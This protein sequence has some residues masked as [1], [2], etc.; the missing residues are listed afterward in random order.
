MRTWLALLIP[1]SHTGAG[2]LHLLGEVLSDFGPKVETSPRSPASMVSAI[3]LSGRVQMESER[4][5]CA[6]NDLLRNGGC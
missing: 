4:D 3:D 6:A 1:W 2:T 5:N